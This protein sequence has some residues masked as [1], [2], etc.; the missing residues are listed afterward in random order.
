[1]STEDPEPKLFSADEGLPEGKYP[2]FYVLLRCVVSVV[3]G[4][5]A[6]VLGGL[7]GFFV[8]GTLDERLGRPFGSSYG[9]ITIGHLTTSGTVGFA[10]V[11][12]A[13][14]AW[15][16]HEWLGGRGRFWWGLGALLLCAGATVVLSSR[17]ID[18]VFPALVFFPLAAV[19]GLELGGV[20][21]G[22][23]EDTD[24]RDG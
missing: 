19:V 2:Q 3:M 14:G 5:G 13:L 7:I 8:V 21:M 15:I 22:P 17:L 11:A 24:S 20:V 1:M 6:M 16:G 23:P 12:A 18:S 9:F 4:A 10:F